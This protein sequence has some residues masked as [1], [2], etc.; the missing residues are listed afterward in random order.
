[1][2]LQLVESS[3]KTVLA[4]KNIHLAYAINKQHKR[5]ILQDFSFSL[6]EREIIMLL[7]A[8]GVGKSSLLR[9]LA[10]LQQAEQGQVFINGALVKSAHPR[11]SFMFQDPS[12]LPWLSVE[13]NV[14]FGLNFKHQPNLSKAE[15]KQRVAQVLQDVGLL[16]VAKA[17]PSALSGG[18]AQRVALAR[19]LAR[20][21]EILL[22]DEPFSALD[23]VTRSE[24]QK[25]LKIVCHKYGTAVVMVT[26]D[27]DEALT[28]ADRVLVVGQQPGRLLGDF[29]IS[30]ERTEQELEQIRNNVLSGLRDVQQSEAA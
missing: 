27:I 26:H 7:G 9:V 10:G 22:L 25:L 11:L 3:K 12:L 8:S 21:P 2:S 20:Q 29:A 1:M 23:E 4:A 28:L 13:D 15:R 18:M 6:Q 19:S 24:M 17:K 14:A 30:I 16:Q 5:T